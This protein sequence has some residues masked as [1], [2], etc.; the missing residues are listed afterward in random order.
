MKIVA[1][2]F[3][4]AAI[5]TIGILAAG[6][7]N[8]R[9]AIADIERNPGRFSNRDVRIAGVVNDSFGVSLPGSPVRGGVY[10]VDDGTGSIWVLTQEAVPARGTRIGVRGTVGTGVTFGGRNFGLGVL[11]RDRQFKR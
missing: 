3:L 10:R 9:T 2:T 11:E 8:N 1:R 7:P 5:A 4:I 6:C